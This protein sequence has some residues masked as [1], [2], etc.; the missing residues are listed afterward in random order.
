MGATLDCIL[1]NT[2]NSFIVAVKKGAEGGASVSRLLEVY[3][4][5]NIIIILI[6]NYN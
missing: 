3:C 4:K 5:Q 1:I 2:L 6:M